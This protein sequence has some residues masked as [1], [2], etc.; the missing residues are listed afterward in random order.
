MAEMPQQVTVELTPRC[1]A[2]WLKVHNLSHNPRVRFQVSVNRSLAGLM[3]FLH[4]K[5]KGPKDRLVSLALMCYA[6]LKVD[7]L[8]S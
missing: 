8:L 5:W 6:R 1:S 4:K 2:A 7:T 3:D